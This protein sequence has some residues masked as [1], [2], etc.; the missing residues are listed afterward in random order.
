MT[1]YF[2]EKATLMY[3]CLPVI[4]AM[5]YAFMITMCIF[6]NLIKLQ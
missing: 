5:L 3:V 6:M 1:L 4:A 2:K